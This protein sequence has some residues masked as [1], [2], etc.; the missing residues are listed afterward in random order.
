MINHH[1][2]GKFWHA[3]H[4]TCSIYDLAYRGVLVTDDH[5][6]SY[7]GSKPMEEIQ[8]FR[9]AHARKQ[10]FVTSGKTYHFMRKHWSDD[11]NLVIIKE[12]AVHIDRHIH[13]KQPATQLLNIFG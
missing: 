11:D 8:N 7:N 4:R 10:V 3:N 13:G 12:S 5:G 9:P 2:E 6:V 1:A